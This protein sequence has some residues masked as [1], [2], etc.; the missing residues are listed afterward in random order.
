MSVHWRAASALA[1]ALVLSSL[2]AMADP[3]RPEARGLL[4]GPLQVGLREGEL[5]LAHRACATSE[6]VLQGEGNAVVDLD[7]FYGQLRGGVRLSGSYALGDATELFG[8]LE[9]FRY[10]TVISSVSAEVA[11]LGHLSL[12]GMHRFWTQGDL[13]LAG[14]GRLVLP[15]ATGL[16]RHARPLGLDAGVTAEQALGTRWRLYGQLGLL[17]SAAISEVDNQP[18]LGLSAT[19][20][21]GWQAF[22]WLAV[23]AQLHATSGYTAALDV[24]AMGLG[25]RAGGERLGVEL[26]TLVPVAGQRS[27]LSLVLRAS[28]SL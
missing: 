28:W 15:T 17:A 9:L 12:G 10:Q 14:V 16:Y 8:S 20:G 25:V 6:V 22:S 21:G 4:L 3:C 24:F 5:G 26:S 7:A 27:P 13:T 11:G 19:V 18:R 2:P 23:L 1:L